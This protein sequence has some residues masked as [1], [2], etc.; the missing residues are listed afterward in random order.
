MIGDKVMQIFSFRVYFPSVPPAATCLPIA[1]PFA[2]KRR[3]DSTE[4]LIN[5]TSIADHFNNSGH[6][7]SPDDFTILCDTNHV[8]D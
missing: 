3:K 6:T 1:V 8:I 2:A 5:Q 7:T 4:M